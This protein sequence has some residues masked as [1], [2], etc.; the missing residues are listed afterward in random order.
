MFLK[1]AGPTH[2]L[3]G[4]FNQFDPPHILPVEGVLGSA[5]PA[6]RAK[7]F[8]YHRSSWPSVLVLYHTT[9]PIKGQSFR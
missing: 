6:D 9:T 2:F 8:K 1:V 7:P 4:T 3:L 5:G